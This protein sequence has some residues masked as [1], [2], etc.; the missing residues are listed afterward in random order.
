[1]RKLLLLILF[2][3]IFPQNDSYSHFEFYPMHI[4]DIWQYR[5]SANNN[6]TYHTYQIVGDT[7]MPN[8][9]SYFIKERENSTYTQYLRVDTAS[10]TVLSYDIQSCTTNSEMLSIP[11]ISYNDTTTTIT[12]CF[13]SFV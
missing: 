4:G 11:L 1:M 10:S 5:I 13:E 6:T 7:I 2:Q 9:E 12:D 8:G 3:V